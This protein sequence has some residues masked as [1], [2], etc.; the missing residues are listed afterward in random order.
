MEKILI[1][2]FL[3]TLLIIMQYIFLNLFQFY[4]CSMSVVVVVV[5]IIIIIVIITTTTTTSTTTTST[6]I[7][8]S[9]LWIFDI[10]FLFH[11]VF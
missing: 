1:E 11:T 5:I 9:V 10:Y 4:F 8:V 3:S 6:I 2:F 7:V